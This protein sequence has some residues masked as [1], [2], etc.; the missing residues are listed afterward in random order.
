M[1][2][3][4]DFTNILNY[5][6][7]QTVDD[8][9]SN[10]K[11]LILSEK[12]KTTTLFENTLDQ[13]TFSSNDYK[14]LRKFLISW[15]TAH[16]VLTTVQKQV[17]D[18][19]S[20]PEE[21][22]NELIRS[23][24]YPYP[25]DISFV[26]KV[27]FFL[28]LVNLY[29][30]K[31]TPQ[32]LSSLLGYFG[33]NN[34]DI[35]EYLLQFDSHKRLVF[36]SL[37]IITQNLTRNVPWSDVPY[38]HLTDDDPHWMLSEQECLN[39][40]AINKI[41]FPSKSPYF[42]VRPAY[43]MD[44]VIY[45]V[46]SLISK[47]VRDE[48]N[49]W[50]ST[51]TLNQVI[52]LSKLNFKVSFLELYEATCYA[53]IEYFERTQHNPKV[54]GDVFCYDGSNTTIVDIIDEYKTLTESTLI[55]RDSRKQGLINF[56][57]IFTK[58][59]FDLQTN[60]NNPGIFLNTVNKSF[61][62]TI[63]SWITSN[64]GLTILIYLLQDLTEWVSNTYG[65][66]YST[67]FG[68]MLGLEAFQDLTNAINFFKPYRARLVLMQSAFIFD[69]PLTD[70]VRL[71]ELVAPKYELTF[72]DWDTADSHPCCP[73]IICNDS[74]AILHYSRQTWDCGSYFDQGAAQDDDSP[75]ISVYLDPFGSERVICY[76][77]HDSTSHIQ[78]DYMIDS[79]GEVV[80]AQ[81]TA[82]WIDFDSGGTF[83][84]PKGNDAV[85][86]YVYD[87]VPGG[88]TPSPP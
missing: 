79:T 20:M 78:T 60:I 83:D 13:I 46:M 57:R 43:H 53:F 9:D 71:A 33:Y 23:F 10:M 17:T 37:P 14:R 35:T 87:V 2:S 72:V 52:T 66:I 12:G 68:I 54:S 59:Q 22:L 3:I 24:G 41:A 62:D 61:K 16:K 82:G 4:D 64:K 5:L 7:G 26:S 67:V 85:L 65:T 21:H 30:I 32:A 88:P 76:K 75:D 40:E 70:S 73:G 81:Q 15:Y 63:D 31:G 8:L 86:I 45:P 36:R 50:Y 29:K 27:N 80:F 6:M 56:Y 28:D 47:K 34:I 74:T 77:P 18:V 48:Y 1:F 42:G 11:S 25:I 58:N 39:L 38:A 44:S 84:C 51:G 69:N 55:D 19:F 49:V